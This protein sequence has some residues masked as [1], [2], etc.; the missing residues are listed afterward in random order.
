MRSLGQKKISNHIEF[1]L[2]HGKWNSTINGHEW[3][4]MV[5]QQWSVLTH[6]QMYS[7][8]ISICRRSF[9]AASGHKCLWPCRAVE[10]CPTIAWR[11]SLPAR[12]WCYISGLTGKAEI[13]TWGSW[14]FILFVFE[15]MMVMM[16]LHECIIDL[17][18]DMCPKY[19]FIQVGLELCIYPRAVISLCIY[20][21]KLHV[22]HPGSLELVV[23]GPLA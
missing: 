21:C 2:G 22:H 4:W 18:R 19:C 15:L 16:I 14:G 17:C 7:S 9:V 3:S 13:L 11:T 10:G 6:L 1:L 12:S 5:M 8:R 23:S 20:I